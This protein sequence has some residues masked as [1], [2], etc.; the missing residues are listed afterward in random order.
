MGWNGTDRDGAEWGGMGGAGRNGAARHG[1]EWDGMGWN[2]S[3]WS[4]TERNR[5]MRSQQAS[6]RVPLTACS[7]VGSVAYASLCEDHPLNEVS[8]AVIGC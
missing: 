8:V 7:A 3:G 1:A 5:T 2:G 4:E 6:R